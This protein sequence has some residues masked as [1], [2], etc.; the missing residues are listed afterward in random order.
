MAGSQGRRHTVMA[1]RAAFQAEMD[2]LWWVA[3]GRRC[4]PAGAPVWARYTQG[5]SPVA[6]R[7]RSQL[8]RAWCRV[9]TSAAA[10]RGVLPE[11]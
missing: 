2:A 7:S 3:R 4:G 5:Q 6:P 10:C 9:S 8:M 11:A 1:G